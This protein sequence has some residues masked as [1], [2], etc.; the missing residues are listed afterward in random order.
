M[1]SLAFVGSRTWLLDRRYEIPLRIVRRWKQSCDQYGLLSLNEWI[2]AAH[3]LTDLQLE[4]V[5][6]VRLRG[7]SPA[8]FPTTPPSW[9]SRTGLAALPR[10][11]AGGSA[12][13]LARP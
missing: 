5:V 7:G 4:N 9:R 11:D 13:A 1:A 2:E 8:R 10:A 6:Q 12:S 3:A